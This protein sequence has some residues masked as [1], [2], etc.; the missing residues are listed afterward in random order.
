MSSKLALGLMSWRRS[1]ARGDQRSDSVEPV[2]S[3]CMRSLIR[4]WLSY[5]Q[6]RSHH[7]PAALTLS[8]G[9]S[10]IQIRT[11]TRKPA[12]AA[13]HSL[14]RAAVTSNGAGW[15]GLDT[16]DHVLG[17]I[18]LR[19]PG[20]P[21]LRQVFVLETEGLH[22]LQ[23][24]W[25]ERASRRCAVTPRCRCPSDTA[26]PC[27]ALAL[28]LA[29]IGREG[30]HGCSMCVG[31]SCRA[32]DVWMTRHGRRR[33]PSAGTHCCNMTASRLRRLHLGDRFSSTLPVDRIS[34]PGAPHV[35]AFGARPPPAPPRRARPTQP[36]TRR[37]P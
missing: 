28:A 33:A 24:L 36:T 37:G 12:D 16:L 9:G 17:H 8:S 13:T 7:A 26:S 3:S 4:R 5:H 30:R 19:R 32:E 27:L 22:L 14:S 21:L 1:G 23:H 31:Q 35:C 18:R 34:H 11:L 2:V 10:V 25:I 29:T 6:A 15:Q 20:A